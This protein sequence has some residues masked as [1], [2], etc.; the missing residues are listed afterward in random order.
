[1][2]RSKRF[3]TGILLI[4]LLAGAPAWGDPAQ[5]EVRYA[6]GRLT[7]KL[8]RV[9]IAVVM[10]RIG[11]ATGATVRGDI[12]FGEVTVTV[13]N[14][15]IS[16]ALD[17]V[18]GSHSF[19][20]TYGAGGALRTIDLLGSGPPVTPGM[21]MMPVPVAGATPAR[22]LAAE[23]QQAAVLQQNVPA[24]GALKGAF[25]EEPLTVG[26]LLH[27]VVN[28]QRPEVR[29]A[30]RESVLSAFLEHPEVE[31]AYLSTLTAVDDTTL[32]SMMRAASPDGSATDWMSAV[33][34]RA[35]SPELKQKAAAIV[36][37]LRGAPAP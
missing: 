27:A 32:A 37:L 13:E 21:P 33:A 20:L 23:E 19:M 1:M 8:E 34:Q 4:G 15:P 2:R 31:A 10:R 22:A 9:P 17:T 3:G 35:R 30:A 11:E 7:L 16:L 12:P 18:L 25:G 36:T 28:D 6:D 26:R 14:V 5:P 29:A 24:W